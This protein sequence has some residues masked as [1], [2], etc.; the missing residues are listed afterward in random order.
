MSSI[1]NVSDKMTTLFG[2]KVLIRPFVFTVTLTFEL[3]PLT[4]WPQNLASTQSTKAEKTHAT[5]RLHG[6]M[7]HKTGVIANWGFTLEKKNFL[8]FLLLWP[9][10]WPDDLH[11]R[12]WPVIHRCATGCA[13]MNF[14][15]QGFRNLSS[16]RQTR[17]KLYTTRL[18]GWSIN[19]N[20]I[21]LYGNV[22]HVTW[23]LELLLMVR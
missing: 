14:L 10:P 18:R 13:N 15:C 4:F 5:G 8:P 16:D 7:F 19:S 22:H 17:P 21:S 3:W 11:I 1:L 23:R 20:H 12:T 2:P 6:C 9:W